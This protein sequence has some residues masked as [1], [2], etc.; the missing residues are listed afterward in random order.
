MKLVTHP[1]LIKAAGTPSKEIQEFFGRVNTGTAELSIAR[2][3]SP[4][5]WAE[6][7]QTPEFAEYTLVLRGA[8]H[9]AIKGQTTIVK[10]GQAILVEAGETVQ[11]ST[12]DPG[13]AEY[14]AICVPAFSPDTVHRAG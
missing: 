9:A 7:A 11:Y 8:L 2:M 1:T 12:P 4:Q 3:I 6:P 10:A 14:V 5:G 13:G